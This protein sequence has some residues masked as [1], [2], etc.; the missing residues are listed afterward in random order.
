MEIWSNG[1]ME[2]TSVVHHLYVWMRKAWIRNGLPPPD[3]VA[4]LAS[5]DANEFL[6]ICTKMD[7]VTTPRT[8]GLVPRPSA[9]NWLPPQ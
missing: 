9:R 4:K 7:G 3:V 5:R 8:E 1:M 6:A 2:E